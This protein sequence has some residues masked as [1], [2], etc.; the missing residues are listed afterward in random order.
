M[1]IGIDIDNVLCTTT[2]AV[3][4]VYNEDAE[5]NLKIENIKSY[6]IENF[7]KSEFRENFYSYFLN[8]R[9]WKRIK[10]INQCQEYVARLYRDGHTI[11]FV[12]STEPENLK[13]KANWI[14]RNFPYINVRKSL[15]SCPRK[16][17]MS[18]IDVLVDD[19]PQNLE[20][21]S[22][23][24]ILLDYP[25]NEYFVTD[26]KKFFRAKSWEEIYN[27]IYNMEQEKVVKALYNLGDVT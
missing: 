8:K 7:V 2:K 1:I 16:Q 23:K 6:Y 27:I 15:F 21:A 17:Y 12:T 20:G 26:N 3:L 19:A 14:T 25:W 22:Y 9:V 10:L 5:D 24:G 13:K 11:L 18:G 4:S